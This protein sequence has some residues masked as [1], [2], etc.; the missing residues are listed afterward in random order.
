[1]ADPLTWTMA[2]SAGSSALSGGLGFLGSR[3]SAAMTEANAKYQAQVARNRAMVGDWNAAGALRDAAAAAQ[4]A[5]D[6]SEAGAGNLIQQGA[7]DRADIGEV[8]TA[9]AS[10]GLVGDG[11]VLSTL[12]M[13]AKRNQLGVATD[14]QNRVNEF[15]SQEAAYRQESADL[16]TGA[17]SDRADAIVMKRSGRAEA[18]AQRIQGYASLIQGVGSSA[19]TFLTGMQSPTIRSDINRLLRRK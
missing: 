15:R 6:A 5:N 10:S 8:E 14:T 11:R 19:N 9:M 12:K 18:S 16:K 1:M 3:Q 2:F 7:N 4:N 17:A 13:I